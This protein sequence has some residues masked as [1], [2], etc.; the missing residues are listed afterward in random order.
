MIPAGVH[1]R[2]RPGRRREESHGQIGYTLSTEEHA[3][4]TLVRYARPAEEAGF[5]F[6]SISDHYHPW[7]RV[8]G[9]SPFD[10]IVLGG[11]RRSRSG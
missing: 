2:Q 11:S 4:P 6:V 7:T 10:W 5:D 9:Q 1:E 8:E 3:A